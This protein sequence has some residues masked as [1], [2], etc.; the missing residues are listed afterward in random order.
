ML[1]HGP[2]GR[3]V[4]IVAAQTGKGGEGVHALNMGSDPLGNPGEVRLQE[5]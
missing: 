1:G 2:V 4:R 3:H 5:A